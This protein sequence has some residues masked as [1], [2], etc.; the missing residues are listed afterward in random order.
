MILKCSEECDDSKENPLF[1]VSVIMSEDRFVAYDIH[2]KDP[3]DFRCVHCGAE[4][5]EVRE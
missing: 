2:E 4:A 3:R 5:K 1:N